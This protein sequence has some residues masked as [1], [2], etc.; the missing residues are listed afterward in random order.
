MLLNIA[1][2]CVS[3][4]ANGPGRRFT[5]WVQGC[6]RGCPGCFNPGLQPPEPR[7]EASAEEIAREARSQ[8]EIDGVSLTGGEPFDQAE[9]LA[10]FLDLLQP[11]TGRRALTVIAFTGYSLDELRAGS[12]ERRHLLDRVDLLVDGPYISELQADLALRGSS[13]QRLYALTPTGEAVR[14]A[15]ERTGRTVTEI[16]IAPDGEIVFTGFPPWELL[17]RVTQRL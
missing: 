8:G 2:T 7:R 16:L 1:H 13:N 17:R 15:V 4:E 14:A 11:P 6:S 10:R 3:R 9:A 5:V 12:P